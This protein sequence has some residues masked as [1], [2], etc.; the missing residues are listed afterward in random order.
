MLQ[1]SR[2]VAG[3][4]YAGK[5]TANDRNERQHIEHDQLAGWVDWAEA[6]AAAGQSAAAGSDGQQVYTNW[7]G[8]E[9]SSRR[10]GRIDSTVRG[11]TNETVSPVSFASIVFS[12]D[13]SSSLLEKQDISS[14]LCIKHGALRGTYSHGSQPTAREAL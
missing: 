12:G 9:P 7:R 14:F 4:D 10:H 13:W 11:L 8:V 3:S 1:N 5:A 2:I 6:P